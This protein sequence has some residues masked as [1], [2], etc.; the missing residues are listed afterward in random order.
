MPSPLLNQP[1]IKKLYVNNTHEIC[2]NSH[3]SRKYF[4][5]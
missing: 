1:K 3:G 5:R 4:T 2:M